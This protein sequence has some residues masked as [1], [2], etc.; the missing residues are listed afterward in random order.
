[1][2]FFGEEKTQKKKKKVRNQRIVSFQVFK[3]SSKEFGD[4]HARIDKREG[5]VI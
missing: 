5:M 4:F 2:R 1:V 3:K